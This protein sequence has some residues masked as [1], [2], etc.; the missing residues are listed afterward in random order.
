MVEIGLEMSLEMQN[1]LPDKFV[2]GD[3]LGMSH[4]DIE[5]DWTVEAIGVWLRA[6]EMPLPKLLSLYRLRQFP[7]KSPAFPPYH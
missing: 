1:N 2:P 4:R 7:P 5:S 3:M 6:C